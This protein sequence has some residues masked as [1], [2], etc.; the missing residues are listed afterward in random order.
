[1]IKGGCVLILFAF[2]A[3]FL[4]L[5]RIKMILQEYFIGTKYI[6]QKEEQALW[7]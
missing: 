1:M 4:C 6:I 5:L 3:M 2:F 7:I